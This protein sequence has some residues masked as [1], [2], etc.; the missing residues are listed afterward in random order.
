V[1]I[2]NP[3]P[4]VEHPGRP[5]SLLGAAIHAGYQ[6]HIALVNNRGDPIPEKL[7]HDK[8]KDEIVIDQPPQV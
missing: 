2:G 6:S 5:N 4:V 7:S 8:A 1:N 3:Y